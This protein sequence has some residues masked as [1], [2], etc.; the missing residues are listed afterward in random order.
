MKLIGLKMLLIP[1]IFEIMPQ[2]I[3]FLN[4][5]IRIIFI[6]QIFNLW[7]LN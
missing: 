1:M 7:G 5:L 3:D 4:H 2:L 6:N